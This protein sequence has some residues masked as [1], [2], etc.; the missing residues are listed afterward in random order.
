MLIE[1]WGMSKFV[2]LFLIWL[3]KMAILGISHFKVKVKKKNIL[4]NPT[5]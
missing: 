5:F 4:N 1:M 2:F 3:L